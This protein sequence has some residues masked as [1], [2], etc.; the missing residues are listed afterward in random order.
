[1]T[2][3]P[4]WEGGFRRFRGQAATAWR[5]VVVAAV[6]AASAKSAG[7]ILPGVRKPSRWTRS[8][9]TTN[10]LSL[11]RRCWQHH[12]S[13]SASRSAETGST[14]PPPASHDRERLTVARWIIERERCDGA[15]TA[16]SWQ[17][18]VSVDTSV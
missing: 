15:I 12:S 1:M 6:A 9:P 17:I 10:P 14:R 4:A 2:P 16:A 13:P 5:R 18:L 7:P 11:V 3:K 8:H